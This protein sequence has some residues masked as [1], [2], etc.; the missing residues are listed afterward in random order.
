[1]FGRCES[2]FLAI[3]SMVYV[4]TS[5]NLVFQCIR[6]EKVV[7]LRILITRS[8]IPILFLLATFFRYMGGLSQVSWLSDLWFTFWPPKT[9]FF[10]AYKLEKLYSY[11]S[12]L[13]RVWFPFCFFLE[14]SLDVWEVWVKFLVYRIYGLHFDPPNPKTQFLKVDELKKQFSCIS[15]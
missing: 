5:Q 7:F 11:I 15:K 8:P 2:S 9:Q 3:G 1:M 14:L 10:N 4:L 6:G 12:W 13:P